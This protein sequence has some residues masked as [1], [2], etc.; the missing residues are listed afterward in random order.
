LPWYDQR[1]PHTKAYEKHVLLELVNSTVSDVSIKEGLGYEAVMGI[2]DSHLGT[3]VDW[4]SI[5]QLGVVGLDEIALKKGHQDFVTIVSA[6]CGEQSTVLAVVEGRK[7]EAI[8]AFLLT[9]PTAL[10]GTI[11]A[12]CTDMYDGYINAAKAVFGK[13]VP[14]VTDRFHVAKL[15]RKSVEGAFPFSRSSEQ[16]R[17]MGICHAFQHVPAS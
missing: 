5:S 9:I 12:V 11:E 16:E 13:S 4:R 17:T 3:A 7:K 8:K 2:I 1:S 14:I 6:R 10:R 15:Y